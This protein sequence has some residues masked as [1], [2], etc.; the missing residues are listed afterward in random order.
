MCPITCENID[1]QPIACP[2]M[3]V[4]GCFCPHGTVEHGKKCV[5]T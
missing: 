1:E 5:R 4:P 2:L 3:C